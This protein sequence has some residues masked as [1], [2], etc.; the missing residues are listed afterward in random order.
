MSESTEG[1]QRMRSMRQLPRRVRCGHSPPSHRFHRHRRRQPGEE[2]MQ[3]RSTTNLSWRS[4]ILIDGTSGGC[5]AH[6]RL[7]AVIAQVTCGPFCIG[8][9]GICKLLAGAVFCLTCAVS[10]CYHFSSRAA[11][12]GDIYAIKIPL[13]SLSSVSLPRALHSTRKHSFPLPL[14]LS[15]CVRPAEAATVVREDDFIMQEVRASNCKRRAMLLPSFMTC[16]TSAAQTA[17]VLSG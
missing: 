8:V 12:P 16:H 11:R 1:A 13:F 14:A 6:T 15:A 2:S 3:T 4:L 10:V 9:G 5:A 7:P 17:C